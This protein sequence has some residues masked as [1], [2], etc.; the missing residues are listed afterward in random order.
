VIIIS[1]WREIKVREESVKN[2]RTPL[3]MVHTFVPSTQEAGRSEF[4]ASLVYRV[5]SRTARATQ[6]NP[7]LQRG[8]GGGGFGVEEGGGGEHKCHVYVHQHIILAI[9]LKI[10]I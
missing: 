7:V 3:K 1:I 4:E 9:S 8:R 10:L 2:W 6:R 5:S